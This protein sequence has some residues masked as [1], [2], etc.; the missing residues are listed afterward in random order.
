M[1]KQTYNLLLADDDEDDCLFFKDA[2]E[3]LSF[4]VELTTVNDGV[5]L[6]SFLLDTSATLPDILFLDLNM[7][8][9]SGCECL[10]EIKSID[11]LKHIPIIVFSTSLD[12]KIVDTMYEKG[13]AYYIQKPG[14]FFKLKKVIENALII[15]SENNF[16]QP[17]RDYFIL[18]P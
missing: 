12:M 11:Q 5:E 4:S 16:K 9:K 3:E 15:S 7:P 10:I 18:Q 17:V 13:A 14:E 1:I 2:L 6:M 8:R